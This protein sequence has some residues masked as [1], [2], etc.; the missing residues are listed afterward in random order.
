MKKCLIV[1]FMAITAL[2]STARE[3]DF[4][5][6]IVATSDV[7]GNFLSYDY[8]ER[9]PRA[10]GLSRGQTYIGDLRRKIGGD[11]VILL[12]NGDILQGQPLTYYY[13]FVDTVSTHVCAAVLNY[14][15]YDAVVVGNH[16]V[17]TGHEVYDRWASACQCP[18]LGGNVVDTATGCPY[19]QP[20]TVIERGGLRVAVLG[21]TTPGIPLWLPEKLWS[22]MRF[23]DMVE[24]ARHW[25]PVIQ[26][27]ERP[28][29]IVGLFHSGAGSPDAAGRL[30]EN[31]AL[32]V[33]REVAGFDL[34]IC[35]H[36]HREAVMTVKN[37]LTGTDVKVLNPAAH[38]MKVAVANIKVRKNGE[39]N[40]RTA[41][42]GTV[43]D[44][45]ALA[46]DPGYMAAFAPSHKAVMNY[47]SEVIGHNTALLS[48]RQAYF[49]PSPFIDFIHTLQLDV[50]GADISFCAPL[51]FDAKIPAGSVRVSD[52]FNLYKYE[53]QL[54]VMRLTG[55]E[56]KRYLEYSYAIWTRRMSDAS[57][58]M[59]LFRL[60][61][62]K[63][64]VGWERL[65]HP[66]YNFDSAAGLRYTVDLT[67]PKGE[68]I[69]IQELSDG[70]PFELDKE[71]RVALNSYRGGGGGDLLTVGAGLPKDSLE[72]RILWRTDR[73]LRHYLI[74]AIRRQ[75]TIH[76]QALGE[77]KFVPEKWVEEAAKRD[78]ELLFR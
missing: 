59:L 56:I 52:M 71:Y 58:H 38:G 25:I 12:D 28:D 6:S 40:I 19:W 5:V 47:I 2:A 49:G 41:I 13:N 62:E 35:G 76:P 46:P 61:A 3:R 53:N 43:E 77:W 4:S 60:D 69:T 66:A 63:I 8:I 73:D 26:R 51:A 34:I 30:Q 54:Y 39:K 1:L 10:G 72:G 31:A 48:T 36:D 29:V 55:E 65:V 15:G 68:K 42:E 7:H 50:S 78:A 11:N 32:R 9:Q 45:S 27:N 44:I 67:K 24:T 70:R 57:E 64:S 14:I 18:V 23:D 37:R 74:E 22:G 75:G 16:D 21:L 17:E 33:A 20:Y